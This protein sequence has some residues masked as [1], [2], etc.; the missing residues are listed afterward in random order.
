MPLNLRC[1]NDLTSKRFNTEGISTI[2]SEEQ[3]NNSILLGYIY[4]NKF[5]IQITFYLGKS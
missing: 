2:T 5:L 4:V 1:Y 3:V